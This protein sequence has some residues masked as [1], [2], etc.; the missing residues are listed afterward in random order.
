MLYPRRGHFDR[1]IEPEEHM[2]L[3]APNR[4]PIATI[5]DDFDRIF[6]Q[7]ST[8]ALFG[9]PAPAGEKMW[10][11]SLDFSEN[12]KEFV[13]R[14]EVPGI[15]KDDLEVTVDGRVLTVSGRRTFE[16]ENKTEE[17]FWRE[18]EQGRFVRVMHLPGAVNAA[19]IAATCQEGVMTVRLPKAEPTIKSR[20]Q[21]K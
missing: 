1:I 2:K 13:V 4:F 9:H 17:F 14:L 19:N 18:R 16:Q 12:E 6:D 15:P 3:I 5:R 20:I 11:P 7:F 21:I 8:S 10:T